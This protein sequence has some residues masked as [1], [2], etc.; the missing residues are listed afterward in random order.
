MIMESAA[1]KRAFIIGYKADK[2]FKFPLPNKS[3]VSVRDAISDLPILH[4][5]EGEPFYNYTEN[6]FSIYQTK[7][8]EKSTGIYNH[9]ATNHSKTALEKLRLIP[10]YGNKNN[11]PDHLKTRSIYSGTWS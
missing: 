5:G 11:L 1:K 3:H 2:Q 8:R 9:I 6:A 4:S 7:L 10:P